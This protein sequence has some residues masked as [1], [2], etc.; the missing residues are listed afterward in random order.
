MTHIDLLIHSAAQVVTCASPNGPRRGAAMCDAGVIAHGAVAITAGKIVAV[1]KSD[2][3]R[4][5]FQ[6]SDEL[7]ASGKAITPGFV[8]PHTHVVYAGDRVAEWELKLRGASYLEILESGGG[9]VSTMRATRAAS[10]EELVAQSGKRLR[11]MLR[12]GTTTAECKTGYGLDL[13][14]ELKMLRAMALLQAAQPITLVLTLLAAH[15]V[16][17]EYKGR[18]DEYVDLIVNEII[19]RVTSPHAP[20]PSPAFVDVY[21]EKSAFSVAQAR[22][23]LHAGQLAG[24]RA[25]AHVDQFNELGGV[26]MA[27]ELGAVSVDHL[28]V[29][30]AESIRQIA[31]SAAVAVV[32]PAATFHLGGQNYANARG[33]IDAG[34]ALA[35]CTDINPGSAPCPSMPLVM[36]LACR[37]MR[38]SPAEALNASTINAAHALGLGG[39]VGSLEAGKQA[40]LVILDAPDYRHV[41][42]EFGGNGVERI[43][44]NGKLIEMKEIRNEK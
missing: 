27:L 15:A 23:V 2:D 31:N 35:L 36:A 4:R 6:A 18:A 25:K 28:D 1:G 5:V 34:C 21:C 13:E 40:D 42:Y 43:V 14:N 41:M 3:L 12:L 16:P 9:I 11:E 8:D 32:I 22:R 10:L 39:L 20:T 24:L 7:D 19:P 29:T 38:L 37:F 44:K 33:M 26:G 30:G 17:P